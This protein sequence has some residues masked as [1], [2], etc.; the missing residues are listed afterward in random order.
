MGLTAGILDASRTI[1]GSY[2]TVYVDGK[3]MTNFNECEASVEIQ[4]ADIR[5]AGSRWVAK[6]ITGL[7]GTGRIKGYKVT[8]ELTQK[9]TG[10]TSDDRAKPYYTEIIYKLDDPEAHGYERVRLKNVIFDKIDL[11]SFTPGEIVM[12]EWP[13]TFTD[14]ELLDPIVE[15]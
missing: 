15:S 12:T 1:N 4:K 8:S 7:A 14:Y 11:T 9:H 13:F 10:T 6:K 3:W 2:G 5:P